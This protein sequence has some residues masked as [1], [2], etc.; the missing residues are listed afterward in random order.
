MSS[1]S[2]KNVYS[3]ILENEKSI[4]KSDTEMAFPIN[5]VRSKSLTPISLLQNVNTNL[6]SKR[7]NIFT[8][9]LSKKLIFL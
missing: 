2:E 3:I 9:M 4:D 5:S 6:M 8:L 1:V 7:F